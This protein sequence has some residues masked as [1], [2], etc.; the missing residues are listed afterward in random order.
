MISGCYGLGLTGVRD[1]DSASSVAAHQGAVSCKARLPAHQDTRLHGR[2][3]A[4]R[5]QRAR[6]GSEHSHGCR[7]R[8]RHLWIRKRGAHSKRSD[9]GR[10]R[11]L[12]RCRRLSP[13]QTGGLGAS[14]HRSR[15]GSKGAHRRSSGHYNFCHRLSPHESAD[16]GRRKSTIRNLVSSSTSYRTRCRRRSL[17]SRTRIQ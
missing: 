8:R 2:P 12:N 16:S 9:A 15:R 6:L 10:L 4:C 11:I 5:Y 7:R 3:G 13:H 14:S 1:A 17:S